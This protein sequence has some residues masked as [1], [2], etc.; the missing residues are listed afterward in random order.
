MFAVTVLPHSTALTI[1]QKLSFM[2]MMSE[3]SFATSVPAI[4]IAKPTFA[5]FSYGAS[6]E[7]SPVAATT[8]FIALSR[9]TNLYLSFGEE[10][11]MHLR[12]GIRAL[13][14]S[15]ESFENSG[16]VIAIF[17]RSYSEALTGMM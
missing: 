3:A 5:A 1:V 2:I 6:L 17:L 9:Q 13:A 16:P 11:A 14:S 10:R 15:S 12:V 7:P 8:K 4:P